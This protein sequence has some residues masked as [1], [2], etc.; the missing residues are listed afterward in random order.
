MMDLRKIGFTEY[1][2]KVYTTL[3]KH[4]PLKGAQASKHSRVPHSKTYQ[5][6][7]SLRKKGFVRESGMRPKIFSPVNPE[8]AIKSYIKKRSGEL[9]ETAAG[10]IPTLAGLTKGVEPSVSEKV[11]VVSGY[12]A[13]WKMVEDFY[14]RAEKYVKVMSTYEV[15]HYDSEA[16]T[17]AA[18]GRGV[19]VKRLATKRL[20][21]D[22]KKMQKHKRLGAEVRFFP[23]QEIRLGIMDGV[24]SW[25]M[26]VNPRNLE[27]RVSIHI[28]SREMTKALEHYFDVIWRK[29]EEI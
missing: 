14:H 25:F 7:E 2:N 11:Q 29:A 10:L 16:A 21:D 9:E 12:K 3:L 6:L 28:E 23:V 1:E 8:K 22:V 24:E 4:G 19:K 17:R 26:I 27:D 15:A 5:A 18:V 20:P 13:M